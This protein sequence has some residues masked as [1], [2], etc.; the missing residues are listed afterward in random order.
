MEST[1]IN[2]ATW[3]YICNGDVK[4]TKPIDATQLA[5]W[6]LKYEKALALIKS[7]VNEEMYFHTENVSNTWSKQDI[8]KAEFTVV[9]YSLMTTILIVRLLSS[10]KYLFG[11]FAVDNKVREE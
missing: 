1:S 6:E 9:Y 2:N 3:K 5:K 10:Y 4:P 8:S 7:Y 11:N